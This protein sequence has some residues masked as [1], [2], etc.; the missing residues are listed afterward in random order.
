METPPEGKQP[1][2]VLLGTSSHCV[3]GPEWQTSV[4]AALIYR[5]PHKCYFQDNSS[6]ALTAESRRQDEWNLNLK[7]EEVVFTTTHALGDRTEPMAQ[8]WQSRQRWWNHSEKWDWG[9][10]R[11]QTG[12]T[13]KW[14]DV[15]DG[16]FFHPLVWFRRTCSDKPHH[17]VLTLTFLL[18]TERWAAAASHL[19]VKGS[20]IKLS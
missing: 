2:I 20:W 19:W 7:C 12:P 5:S 14:G 8:R 18:P 17:T 9:F 1:G 3:L 11:V 15:S 10:L 4:R 16:F 13:V 6:W